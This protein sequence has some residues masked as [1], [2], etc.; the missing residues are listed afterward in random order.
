MMFQ[1]RPHGS[2]HPYRHD[3]DQRVPIRPL[4]GEEFEVRVLAD[5]NVSDVYVELDGGDVVE[6]TQVEPTEVVQEFGPFSAGRT[7]EGHLAPAAESG[8]LTAD[9]EV[10]VATVSVRATT[11]YRVIGDS[12]SGRVRSGP[13]SVDPVQWGS[14]GGK[15]TIEG[16]D[17]RLDWSSLSW[18]NSATGPIKARF[19]LRLDP[20]QHITGLGERFATVD[21]RGERLDS[22]VFEQY[23]QQGRRTYLPVPMAIVVGGDHWGFHIDTTRRCWFDIGAGDTDWIWIE[24]EV[25]PLDPQLSVCVWSGEP[26]EVVSLFLQR[27]GRPRRPPRWIFEPWMSGNEWNTQ[28]RVQAEVQRSLAEDIPVGVIVIEAWSDEETFLS[29]RD[30]TYDVHDHGQPHRLSQFTFPADGA[31]PDPKAMVD[32]LHADGVRVLLWQIPLVP[33]HR[34]ETGQLAADVS[35]L[36]SH[37]LCIREAD[38]TPYHN[39]GW[40]FP[41]A[42]IPDFTDPEVRRWWGERRRYLLED[43]G[44]DGFKT[45]GGEH[46]WGHDLKFADGTTGAESN[47]RFP[48]LFAQTYHELFERT[49]I[50]GVTFSRAGFTG[51]AAYPCHWAGDQDSTWEGFQA[52]IRAGI[53]AGV[54]GVFFWGWDLAGFSGPIPDAELYLRATAM[55]CLCPIMQYHSEFN[56][57][58]DPSIDRTPWNIAERTGDPGVIAIYRRFATLRTRLV[59]YLDEQ[60]DQS[61]R[62]SK[63][64]MRHTCFD[65]PDDDTAWGFPL[66]YQLGD[67]LLVAPIT[68]PGTTQIDVHLPDGE[69]IDCFNG[70]HHQ[71]RA[72]V[73]RQVPWHEIA[74]YH[75]AD[76]SQHLSG[77]FDDLPAV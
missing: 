59:D 33:T 21:H 26:Q 77:V 23:K 28:E 58:Q 56:H 11:K 73:S 51:S 65:D 47:N 39:R 71:G 6:A 54:A 76:P 32:R 69:W 63:P 8:S 4:I 70:S 18:L 3:L 68:T 62:T 27:T 31:W 72:T 50:D 14:S 13:H 60:A 52:S 10:W 57:H 9:C 66:Q 74:V 55:A 37:N 17:A 34:A 20:E 19:R 12:P 46:L 38:D 15:L 44:I 5:R 22:I 30:A 61:L 2:G 67:D 45:D 64:L 43:V 41:G 25:D 75:R 53:N 29:F 48:V 49:A 1:H 42:L 16:T 35:T 24:A 40:W 36:Q 7:A